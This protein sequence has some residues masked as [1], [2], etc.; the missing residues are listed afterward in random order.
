MGRERDR[1]HHLPQVQPQAQ[2]KLERGPS[3]QVHRQR[4]VGVIRPE[5][6]DGRAGG[7]TLVRSD[8]EISPAQVVGKAG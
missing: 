1:L 5:G 8:R 7:D 4:R 3:R 6:K 2:P